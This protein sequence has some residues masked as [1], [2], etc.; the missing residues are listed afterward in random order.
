MIE[1]TPIHGLGTCLSRRVSTREDVTLLLPPML[2]HKCVL[3]LPLLHK[4]TQHTRNR[5]IGILSLK[6]LDLNRL[7][8]SGPPDHL[9]RTPRQRTAAKAMSPEQINKTCSPTGQLSM[10]THRKI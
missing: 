6:R 4:I 1:R 3:T 2:S 7:P 5:H 9:I 10:H 8:I